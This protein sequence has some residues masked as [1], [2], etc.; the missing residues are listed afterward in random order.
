MTTALLNDQ[1]LAIN[2]LNRLKV[3]ALFMEPGTGK[4]R[5]AIELINA[6]DCDFCLWL[7][8][9]RTKGN[10]AKELIKWKFNKLNLIVGIETLSSSG[11]TYLA[12]LDELDRHSKNF[13]VLDESLKIKN[14]D[15]IRTKR[16]QILAGKS[17]YRLVLNGT[18][19]SKNILDLWS[20]MNFLSPKIL[21]M[22]HNQFKDTFCNYIKYRKTGKDGRPGKWR[23]FIKKY[24]NL[25][26]LYNLI[27]PFTF[28][29]KLEIDKRKS[30]V[31]VKY[32]IEK[33]LG[34]YEELKEKFIDSLKY[35]DA[36]SYIKLTQ[37]MQHCYCDEP[38]KLKVIEKIVDD[39]TIVF[40]K[41]IKS[42]QIV[43][44]HFPKVIVLTYGT[45]SYGL[46]L[47]DYN[48]IIFFDKTF[49]YSQ[50]E[51]AEHRIYRT[52]QE[53]DC[54]FYDLTGDVNLERTIDNN[55]EYKQ[56][57]LEGLKKLINGGEAKWENII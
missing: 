1:Q 9:F 53:D 25:E 11:K 8:P 33:G 24:E 21:K 32:E 40:T 34:D 29:S 30:Y 41:F 38:N 54:I 31:N 10:L 27:E 56:N 2:K 51:Q 50:R 35:G 12:L 42:K 39:K 14:E 45:G 20:Q 49:D 6:T 48:K 47:Q 4:T 13:I 18:P 46:N 36:D 55:I 22:D 37:A 57:L 43:Q 16:I 44:K 19:L 17:E 23:E 28:D 5:T 3:G 52:G 15:A 7:V 26:Y